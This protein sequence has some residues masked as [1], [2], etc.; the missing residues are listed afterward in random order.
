LFRETPGLENIQ[1]ETMNSRPAPLAHHKVGGNPWS[2]TL[3][4][5]VVLQLLNTAAIHGEEQ[6]QRWIESGEADGDAIFAQAFLDPTNQRDQLTIEDRIFA[7]VLYGDPV[8]AFDCFANAAAKADATDR[9]K[10]PNGVLVRDANFCL[11]DADFAWGDSG[12]YFGAISAG[13]GLTAEQRVVTLREL[14]AYIEV[15]LV[16]SVGKRM[17]GELLKSMQATTDRHSLQPFANGE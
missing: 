8:A 13:S 1:G 9:H 7:V 10:R 4:D 16:N 12:Y 6:I 17:P 14:L 3:N 2:A 5:G 15:S 11:G